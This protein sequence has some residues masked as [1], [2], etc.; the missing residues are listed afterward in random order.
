MSPVVFRIIPPAASLNLL[1]INIRSL[2]LLLIQFLSF[3]LL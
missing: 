2:F 3:I 1:F